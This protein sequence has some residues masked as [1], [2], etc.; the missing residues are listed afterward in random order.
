M[1]D[2][3]LRTQIFQIFDV[4]RATVDVRTLR[5]ANVGLKVCGILA[6]VVQLPREP[7]VLRRPPRRCELAGAL[8]NAAEMLR[9]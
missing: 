1:I 4:S 2:A 9:Q 3:P 7:R 5:A 6:E 8:P